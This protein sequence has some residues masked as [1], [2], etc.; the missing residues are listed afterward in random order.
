[1]REGDG[2]G[3]IPPAATEHV[4]E[5]RRKRGRP[6]INPPP[7]DAEA[8][9]KMKRV[10]REQAEPSIQD[11]RLSALG[12]EQKKLND[13]Q[14]TRELLIKEL[15]HLEAGGSSLAFDSRSPGAVEAFTLYEN[16][17]NATPLQGGSGIG[18][19]AAAAVEQ[20][21][22]QQQLQQLSR[23][24]A[25]LE[26]APNSGVTSLSSSPPTA[27]AN[28]LA[29]G[30]GSS[31]ATLLP[32]PP[33]PRRRRGRPRSR[34][35]SSESDLSEARPAALPKVPV[36]QQTQQHAPASTVAQSPAPAL[37][38]PD[39]GE[40][41]TADVAERASR[42]ASILSRVL[43]L[44]REGLWSVHRQ[45]KPPEPPRRKVH[46]DHLL[47]EMSWLAKDFAEERKW[48]MALAKKVSR[49]VLKYHRELKAKEQLKVRKEEQQIRKLASNIAR[50]VM[51]FWAS[52]EKLVVH[53]HQSQL[54]A[55]KK[56][57]LHKHLDFLVDQTQ[58][59]S[60]LLAQDLH[61]V[62]GSEDSPSS[63]TLAGSK[64]DLSYK[65]NGDVS[66]LSLSLSL[67]FSL[68]LSLSLS[69]SYLFIALP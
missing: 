38:L 6:R 61:A 59:Y 50:D 13:A 3:F 30:G 4:E 55:K 46:W 56:Q 27:S 68:S 35:S 5:K 49:Q 16:P 22:Q 32:P 41:T 34:D 36:D 39:V 9:N 18:A 51:G 12:R 19:V 43:A 66:V 24:E 65:M 62:P 60:T 54:D 44:Q 14:R 52:M 57:A 15:L 64:E 31:T 69:R 48:K 26:L 7:N 8:T 33:P 1:M 25:G 29:S 21:Q 67:S 17:N 53:K 2:V 37:V 42:D 10:K 47:E 45:A 63:M 20:Q 40:D 23:I 58:R 11:L 28:L